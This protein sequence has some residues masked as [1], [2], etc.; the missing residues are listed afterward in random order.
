MK[1]VLLKD[2]KGSG[3]AGDIID[4]KVTHLE[5]F[6]AFVDIG[7]GIISL[8]PIDMISISRISH[9]KDRFYVGQNIKAIVKSIDENR[10]SLTH[11]ELLGTWEENV[12]SFEAGETVSGIIRSVEEYG[13]FVELTPNLAGLAELKSGVSPGQQASVF[14]K[15]MLPDKMKVKPTEQH[16]KDLEVM[17]F[18][19]KDNLYE[20]YEKSNEHKHTEK[21]MVYNTKELIK[22]KVTKFNNT[23]SKF[24]SNGL[25]MFIRAY[26]LSERAISEVC[27]YFAKI[28]CNYKTKMDLLFIHNMDELYVYDLT[29]LKVNKIEIDDDTKNII[30]NVL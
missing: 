15:S 28:Q 5:Q 8:I 13:I 1:V 23:Y 9:P 12:A 29:T 21:E 16:R 11:K 14:I 26:K 30:Y 20:D 19:D 2:V 10:I 3:K 17:V 24:N 6:G 7:C 22:T 18:Y 27:R 25:F 4:A